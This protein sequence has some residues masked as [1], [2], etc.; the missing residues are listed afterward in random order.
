MKEL[1]GNRSERTDLLSDARQVIKRLGLLVL[2][3]AGPNRLAKYA[4]R[5]NLRVLTYHRVAPRDCVA[6]GKRPPDTVFADEFERQMAFVARHL[7]A[8]GGD[9]LRSIVEGT[10][11]IP[12]HALAISFDD[13]YENNFQYALPVLQRYGLSA[14]FFLTTDFIGKDQLL[15]FVRLDR[16]LS[17]APSTVLLERLR[18]LDPSIRV[19]T[20]TQIRPY[21]KGLPAVRQSELLGHLERKLGCP[22]ASDAER[23]VYGMMSWDQVRRLASAGMTIGSH[24]A[25]HQI[26]A[27]VS[28]AEASAELRSSRERI[29]QETGQ[30]CW[31]FAYPNG[32]RRDFRAS[33]ELAARDA[34]YSCAFTQVEGM[35]G[36]HTP[37]YTLPRIPAPNT[38]DLR[39]FETYVFGL[40]HFIKGAYS[41]TVD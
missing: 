14:V 12:H 40:R 38:G 7:D 41:L 25:N 11:D 23:T 16:L 1:L 31:S 13:G 33:D 35:I 20:D 29:E 15:W 36:N 19:P 5:R 27:A 28:S 30:T 4:S 9:R 10:A 17:V 26:L 2:S 8:I 18:E 3:N 34:G 6:A 37:R 22:A 32:Q 21:F 24:T 39:L